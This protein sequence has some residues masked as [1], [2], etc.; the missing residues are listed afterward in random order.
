MMNKLLLLVC[1]LSVLACKKDTADQLPPNLTADPSLNGASFNRAAPYSFRYTATDDQSLRD[2]RI[3]WR[4]KYGD[5]FDLGLNPWEGEEVVG[6]SGQS[7]QIALE[8]NVPAD[9]QPGLYVLT[10]EVSDVDGRKSDLILREFSVVNPANILP[11]VATLSS[12]AIGGTSILAGSNLPIAG[13][14]SDDDGL[15]VV[16]IKI[17][18]TSPPGEGAVIYAQNFTTFNNPRLVQLNETVNFPSTLSPGTATLYLMIVDGDD[19]SAVL[20]RTINIR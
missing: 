17:V 2:A 20:Q 4:H 6:L 15:V 19:N 3:Q 11:P 12:P 7:Q 1:F 18:R 5:W 8:G 9:A 13:L 16:A 10:A 14:F